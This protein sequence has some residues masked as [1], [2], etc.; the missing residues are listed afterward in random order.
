[1]SNQDY[2]LSLLDMLCAAMGGVALL[3]FLFAAMRKNME[4]QAEGSSETLTMRVTVEGIN[5]PPPFCVG[6][7]IGFRLV[8]AESEADVAYLGEEPTDFGT[9]RIIERSAPSPNFRFRLAGTSLPEKFNLTVWL[10][11][12]KSDAN[13]LFTKPDFAIRYEVFSKN[14]VSLQGTLNRENKF[15]H[16]PEK[17]FVP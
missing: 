13:G 1:M 4:L 10:K 2:S 16:Q 6:Q 3:V 11:S 8:N 15:I 9:F 12:V 5:A 7:Q 14:G 17:P